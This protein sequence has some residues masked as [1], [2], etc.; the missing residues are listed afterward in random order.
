MAKVPRIS[1]GSL[2]FSDKVLNKNYALLLRF[3]HITKNNALL[4]RFYIRRMKC[5]RSI[6]PQKGILG[7]KLRATGR[8]FLS[9][10]IFPVTRRNFL[11]N[12]D[13]S[14]HWKKVSVTGKSFLTQEEISCH[15]KTFP[16][17]K[18]FSS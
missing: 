18:E 12:N 8:N 15:R 9:R 3:G 11:L 7:K 6:L 1:A 17:T 14:L 16:V 13:L 10:K 5:F 2:E 4:S